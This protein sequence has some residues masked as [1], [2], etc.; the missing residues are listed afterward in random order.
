MRPSIW[1]TDILILFKETP[2]CLD[3]LAGFLALY[4]QFI[5]LSQQKRSMLSRQFRDS[6][7]R[8]VFQGVLIAP[9][10]GVKGATFL[11]YFE[12]PLLSSEGSV[13]GRL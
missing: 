11:F 9:L 8:Q 7:V 6:Q 3:D 2:S 10:C 12:S 4:C 5:S 1:N 13:V